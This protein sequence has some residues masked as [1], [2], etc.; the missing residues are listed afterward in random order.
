M[1]QGRIGTYKGKL[2]S[3]G[4]DMCI[5]FD[6]FAQEYV[7]EKDSFAA[8]ERYYQLFYFEENFDDID[9]CMEVWLLENMSNAYVRYEKKDLLNPDYINKLR[10]LKFNNHDSI[11]LYMAEW[12][13]PKSVYDEI[14]KT[15]EE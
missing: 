9:E 15:I 4:E 11:P 8:P 12:I 13:V 1:V 6:R 10:D 3:R 14:K 5:F 2:F 7:T